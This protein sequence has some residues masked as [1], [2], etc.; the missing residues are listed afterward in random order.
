[1][2]S[3]TSNYLLLGFLSKWHNLQ[4]HQKITC[5][6]IE[7]LYFE[8]CSPKLWS[9]ICWTGCN[10]WYT[11]KKKGDIYLRV[12][13]IFHNFVLVEVHVEL[14]A[15]FSACYIEKKKDKWARSV[16]GDFQNHFLNKRCSRY[17]KSATLLKMH[18]IVGLF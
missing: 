6:S 1:M 15:T 3:Y 18:Q 7:K 16:F 12:K 5:S 14:R 9:L 17:E 13:K 10:K 2:P 11:F 8:N 4:S